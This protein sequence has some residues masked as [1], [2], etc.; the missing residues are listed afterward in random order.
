MVGGQIRTP[1]PPAADKPKI[2]DAVRVGG[3][4]ALTWTAAVPAAMAVCFLLLIMYFKLIGGY[5]QVHIG[6]ERMAAKLR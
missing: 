3:K 2:D 6:E 4:Q 5:R 1:K